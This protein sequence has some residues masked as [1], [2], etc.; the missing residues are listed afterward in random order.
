[1]EFKSLLSKPYRIYR[2]N[3]FQKIDHIRGSYRLMVILKKIAESGLEKVEEEPEPIYQKEWDNLLILDACRHD[4]YEEVEGETESRITLGSN[5]KEFIR[6][7]FSSGDFSDTVYVTGNPHFFPDIFEDLTGRRP[8]EVFAEV[9]NTYETDWDEENGVVMPQSLIRDAKTAKKLFPDKKL[10]VHFM[11]P[12]TPYVKSDIP[13]SPNNEIGGD[14]GIE[15][16]LR[17]AEKGE[18]S[19]KYVVRDYKENLEFVMSSVKELAIQ[20]EGK[21]AIT[22]D[23]GEL[24]GEA[25]LYGHKSGSRVK[26]LRKVPW[27]EIDISKDLEGVSLGE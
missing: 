15:S 1:M 4:I 3:F 21:T 11:Q 17:R 12:H 27:D 23:H 9:F 6:K 13:Q 5:S 2:H 26:K 14:S 24:L 7:T 20:L 22:A 25:G 8:D 19:R 16:E 10:I 18:I